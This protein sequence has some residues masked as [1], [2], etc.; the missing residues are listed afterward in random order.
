MS[1]I[2]ENEAERVTQTKLRD[3]PFASPRLFF[4]YFGIPHFQEKI[5]PNS[6]L[7]RI[8]DPPELWM[9]WLPL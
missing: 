2:R 7:N 8:Q 4:G 9:M 6:S 3:V 1:N 5:S